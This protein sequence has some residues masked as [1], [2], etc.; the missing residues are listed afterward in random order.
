MTVVEHGSVD[1]ALVAVGKMLQVLVVGGDYSV[2]LLYAELL[3]HC[4]GY[5]A[6][7]LRFRAGTELVNENQRAVVGALHH[8]LHVRQMARIRT[9]VVFYALFVT[10]IYKDVLEYSRLRTLAHR[11]GQTALEHVLQQTDGFQT[12]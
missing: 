6:A 2:C 5:G 3:E 8:I 10:Y 12:D 4:L 1:H 7:D 11:H 9:Q